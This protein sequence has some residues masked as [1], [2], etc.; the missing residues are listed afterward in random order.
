[1]M[2]HDEEPRTLT[3]SAEINTWPVTESEIDRALIAAGFEVT[4]EKE[5]IRLQSLVRAADQRRTDE[6]LSRLGRFADEARSRLGDNASDDDVLEL[7]N[8]LQC[9][10]DSEEQ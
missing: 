10:A 3:E 1:M 6:S 9:E 4:N 5:R 2:T 7:A 8:E